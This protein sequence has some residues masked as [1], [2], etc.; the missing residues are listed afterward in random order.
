MLDNNVSIS[1]LYNFSQGVTGSNPVR[2]TLYSSGQNAYATPW[3]D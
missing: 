2:L 3:S 1:T